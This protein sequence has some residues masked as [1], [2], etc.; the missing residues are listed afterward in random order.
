MGTFVTLQTA[1]K[2][3]IA[4]YLAKPAGK[5]RGGLVICQEIFGVN[6][7]IRKVV[8][9]YAADGFLAIAPAL[10]DRVEKNVEL[11]YD[12]A[13]IAA[14][15]ALMKQASLDNALLDV[16]AA[17]AQVAEA[18]KTGVL[19]YCWGGTV[20]WAAACRVD[21]VAAAVAYYG[22]GIGNL[23]SEKPRCPI[24][25][26]FGNQDQSIP[27]D[28]VEKVKAGHP[29][30]I[31]HVYDAGH[32]FNCDERGSYNAASADLARARSIEFLN[33]NLG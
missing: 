30:A 14:G 9:G 13:G 28:V 27:M 2:Q 4:A 32:G 18:G 26:H 31:V 6:N 24:L 29:D 23:L 12:Q 11:Q 3:S 5:P 22:G 1:D 25:T 17:M 21:G 19:G 33:K 16:R 10:F 15:V 7:H 20:S 8:D